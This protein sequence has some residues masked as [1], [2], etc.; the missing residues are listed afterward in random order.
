MSVCISHVRVG[1]REAERFF[2][3]R[4]RR[5]EAES[6]SEGL[7]RPNGSYQHIWGRWNRTVSDFRDT[8]LHLL[9]LYLWAVHVL[10]PHEPFIGRSQ[11][12]KL[13]S[14]ILR[15]FL[16]L[17]PVSEEI[18]IFKKKTQKLCVKWEIVDRSGC[19]EGSTVGKEIC[20]MSIGQAICFWAW[21]V[22][23]SKRIEKTISGGDFSS[24]L[25]ARG[26]ARNPKMMFGCV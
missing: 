24:E 22:R 19:R 1:T 23:A 9:A 25:L 4:Y 17:H 2:L 10:R 3:F 21:V 7:F 11:D 13:P 15:I 5:A 8:N 18:Y 20:P 12:L 6:K 16:N 26:N 14:T